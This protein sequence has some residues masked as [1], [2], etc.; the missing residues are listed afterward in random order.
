MHKIKITHTHTHQIVSQNYTKTFFSEKKGQKPSQLIIKQVK[1]Y[2][3]KFLQGNRHLKWD[4]NVHSMPYARCKNTSQY[5]IIKNTRFL[6][7]L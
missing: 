7:R 4:V 5:K 6:N 3:N 1:H 2:P